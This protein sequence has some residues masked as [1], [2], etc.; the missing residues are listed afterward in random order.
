MHK[1]AKDITPRPMPAHAQNIQGMTS[2]H[3][4]AI[5]YYGSDGRRSYWIVHCDCGKDFLMQASEFL[6]GK[7]KSCGCARPSEISAARTTHG[8]SKHPLY[9]VWRSMKQRCTVPTCH[10]YPNYGGRGI[11]VCDRWLAKFQNFWDDMNPTYKKGLTLDRIDVN[12]NYCPENCRWVNMKKQGNNKRNNTF[13]NTPWGRITIAEA[14]EKSGIGETTLLYRVQH[15]CPQNYLFSP[16]DVTNR[17][18]I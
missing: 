1:T 16:P 10:A 5:R 11:K 4:T 9:H 13:I 8:L 6:K 3:L 18:T 2:G 14:S 17:F 15:R 12:G 7:Q